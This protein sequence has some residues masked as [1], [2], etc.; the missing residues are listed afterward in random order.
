MTEICPSGEE[1]WQTL[2]GSEYNKDIQAEVFLQIK[3]TVT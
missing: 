3:I 1:L 2:S